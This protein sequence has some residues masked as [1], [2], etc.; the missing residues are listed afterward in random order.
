M[1]QGTCINVVSGEWMNFRSAVSHIR[2][3]NM[4]NSNMYTINIWNGVTV[5]KYND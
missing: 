2:N 3:L 4:N 1:K 5:N